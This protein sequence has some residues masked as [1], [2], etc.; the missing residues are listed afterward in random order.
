MSSVLRLLLFDITMSFD[1]EGNSALPLK[2]HENRNGLSPTETEHWAEIESP[3]L[4]GFSPNVNG[5]TLGA[6]NRRMQ[7]LSFLGSAFFLNLLNLLIRLC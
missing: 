7:L 2:Y 1:S 4:A 5:N 3:E 6:T